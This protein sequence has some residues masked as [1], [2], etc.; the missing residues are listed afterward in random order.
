[1][2]SSALVVLGLKDQLTSPLKGV[3]A[4]V[5]GNL[6]GLTDNTKVIAS[7]IGD[8]TTAF[9]GMAVAIGTAALAFS[10]L[11]SGIGT[12]AKLESSFITTAGD[13]SNFTGVTFGQGLTAVKDMQK[14]IVK[15]GSNLPGNTTGYNQIANAV[16]PSIASGSGGD[17]K[18]MKNDVIEVT[19]TLGLMASTRGVD[20]QLAA[21][22]SAK[23]MSGG[24]SLRELFQINDV[25]QKNPQFKKYLEQ[26]LEA[27][28]LGLKDWKTITQT[29]RNKAVI[30]A[31]KLAYTEDTISKLKETAD[32]SIENLKTKLFDP[33]TGLFGFLRV[34]DVKSDTN[35]LN[36]V[37]NV[38]KALTVLGESLAKQG[39]NLDPMKAI[40]DNLKT[41]SELL[42]AVNDG[43][44]QGNWTKTK[45]ILKSMWKGILEVPKVIGTGL[46]DVVTA[47]KGFDWRN[48]ANLLTDG[49]NS[50]SAGIGAVDWS[51]LGTTFGSAISGVLLDE[52]LGI[53]LEK[54]ITDAL[55]AFAQA[56]GGALQASVKTLMDPQGDTAKGSRRTSN[57]INRFFGINQ[58]MPEPP[59]PVE[60]LPVLPKDTKALQPLAFNPTVNVSGGSGAQDVADMVMV[61]LNQQFTQYRQS[62]I[63]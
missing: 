56:V 50:I 48:L 10:G 4:N 14:E 17:L 5:K 33:Q 6:N 22:A 18:Q 24:T 12:A 13:V 20:M 63:A 28:G 43:V 34:I 16:T 58:E 37:A 51:A 38:V 27:D 32:A 30:D 25:F 49:L 41:L 59:K 29:Q 46:N 40:Y 26:S 8:I 3:M 1:M 44:T 21:N 9:L 11:K 62:V 61:A 57:E 54:S 52:K 7:S 2:S 60:P 19:K 53:A 15:L 55:N 31:G 45:T 47:L 42:T 23:F 39:A 35:S 36:M